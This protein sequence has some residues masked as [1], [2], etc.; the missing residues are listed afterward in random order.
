MKKTVR[1][2]IVLIAL[3]FITISLAF[4]TSIYAQSNE[5]PVD[6]TIGVKEIKIQVFKLPSIDGA[7][8]Y[9]IIS[10]LSFAGIILTIGIILFWVLLILRAAFG[11]YKKSDDPEGMAEAITKMK[12]LFIGV[13]LAF[14]FPIVMTIIGTILGIGSFWSWPVAFQECNGTNPNNGEEYTYFYQAVLGAP[15]GSQDPIRFAYTICKLS[16]DLPY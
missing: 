1:R 8:S 4:G 9:T 13:A 3:S 12:S 15:E 5:L 7:A 16:D 2:L 14:A 11:V 10:W 6:S